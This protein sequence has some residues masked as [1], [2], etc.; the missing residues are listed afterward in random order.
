MSSS[1]VEVTPAGRS[2]IAHHLHPYTQLRQ[3][4]REGPLVIVK[5]DGVYV[6]DEH[7]QRYLEGMAGLWCASLG[8][9]EGRLAAAAERQMRTLPYY[10][11]F[12]GKVPGPVTELVATLMAWAPTPELAAGRVLFSNSGSEANDTAFKLVRYYN[13]ARGRPAKKKI[14]ARQKG[15]HGV[16][17]AAASLSGLPT[18]HQH[19]DLPLPGV[20]RVSAPHYYG[21]SQAEQ[22][23]ADFVNQL[24]QEL[25]DL[26]VREGADTIAAFIAEPVQGAGGVI[27]PPAGYFARVQAILKR[28]DILFIVD[29]VITGFGR[30]GQRFGTQV[31]DLKPDMLTVAKMMTSAYVPMSALFVS[32]AIYQTVA[33]ASAAVGTFGHGYT[34]SGHP[35]ACAVALETL[36]IYE[37]DDVVGHVRRVAPRLQA[38]LQRFAG[39]PIVGQARGLGLIGALE[40]AKDPATRT[41][42]DPKL[43]VGAYFVRRAQDHGLILRVL[44]GDVIAFSPPLIISEPEIDSMLERAAQALEETHTWVR[45]LA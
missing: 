44:G 9:S 5:G 25:E 35:L 14:I 29:E 13:N 20:L 45:G 2:D 43:G 41:P 21:R 12:S 27:I 17:A 10:H 26:I 15:Y 38:G 4:E 7:G 19:F 11:S 8:F 22:S 30:L 37:T 33:D 40:L 42:F 18:M 31:Y 3:L 39:H 34:Y 6:I 36:R 16:T 23:E 32:E 1:P 24:A 28:H